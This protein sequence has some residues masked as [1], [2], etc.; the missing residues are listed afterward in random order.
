MKAETL[1][2]SPAVA[3][4]AGA[5]LVGAAGVVCCD[6]V[7][8]AC[9]AYVAPVVQEELRLPQP[10]PIIDRCFA[11]RAARMNT[12]AC[13]TN[14]E[15]V[16]GR[17]SRLVVAALVGAGS[18]FWALRSGL[19][20]VGVA[21]SR[22]VARVVRPSVDLLGL[23]GF[24]LGRDIAWMNIIRHWRVGPARRVASLRCV[25]VARFS[26]C[27]TSAPAVGQDRHSRKRNRRHCFCI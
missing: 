12:I 10:T 18:W 26:D 2:F 21:S 14:F 17:T 27:M 8:D 9:D 4:P 7:V 16:L 25:F 24:L 5:P 6:V 20:G 13:Q 3:V 19:F 1:V 15:G 22:R 11:V 23:L